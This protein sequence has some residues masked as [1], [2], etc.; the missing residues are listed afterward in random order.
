MDTLALEMLN[1]GNQ[2]ISGLDHLIIDQTELNKGTV[3][4]I[5]LQPCA[6]PQDWKEQWA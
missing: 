2:E 6:S 4:A 5:A 3:S 1:T